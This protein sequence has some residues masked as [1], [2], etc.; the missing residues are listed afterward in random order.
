MRRS[1][2]RIYSN[3]AWGREA[4]GSGPGSTLEATTAVRAMLPQ[5]MNKYNIKTVLDAGCGMMVGAWG[6][7]LAW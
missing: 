1:F 3:Q 4:G 5:L 7:G 2:E 6:A